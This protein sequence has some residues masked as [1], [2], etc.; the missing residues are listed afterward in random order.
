VTTRIADGTTVS[1]SLQYRLDSPTGTVI[2]TSAVAPT[3]GWQTWQSVTASL[4]GTAT[5]VHRVYLTFTGTAGS[6]FVNVN[7]LQFQAA[8]AGNAYTLRQ[9]ENFSS[10]SG[11][12]LETTTDTGGGQNVGFIAPGDWLAYDNVDFGT[13]SPATV[14][15][16]IASGATASGTIQYRLDSTTG[17]VI[18]TVPVSPTGGWQSWQSATASVSAG[19]TGVHR[20]FL[21]F[22]GTAGTDFTNVNWFQ[23][24]H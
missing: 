23:F 17:T 18:A 4:T 20:V 5:G 11:T 13:G 15:T 19:A 3:G 10:Q 7:W 6:D 8:G 16:R 14:T 21:T 9:A 2:A 1:G 12:M 24:N 22:T